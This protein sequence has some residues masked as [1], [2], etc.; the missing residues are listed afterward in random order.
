MKKY[1]LILAFLT[2]FALHAQQLKIYEGDY[3]LSGTGEYN[4]SQTGG[5]FRLGVYVNDYLQ[6]GI[7]AGMSD[8][9]IFNRLSL[10]AYVQYL[11]ETQTYLLPYIGT[12][13]GMSSLDVDG[14]QSESGVDFKLLTGLKYFLADNVSLN[15]EIYFVFGTA[16]TFIDENKLS[17]SDYGL[18]LGISY[19]W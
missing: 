14:G 7:D 11:F 1:F 12:G 13:L 16:E 2:G 10:G 15:T 3:E 17:D 5:N 8:S 18:T 6:V 9:E 19:S 4:Q